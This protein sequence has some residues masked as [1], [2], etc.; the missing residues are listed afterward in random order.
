MTGD[1][2]SL[3][4]QERSSED[5]S[6]VSDEASGTPITQYQIPMVS[7]GSI[8]SIASTETIRPTNAAPGTSPSSHQ[9]RRKINTDCIVV[10]PSPAIVPRTPLL[11][12]QPSAPS[13]LQ[14]I[15]QQP[16]PASIS[17]PR[18]PP[19]SE[20]RHGGPPSI[21]SGTSSIHRSSTRRNPR[22]RAPLQRLSSY[23]QAEPAYSSDEDS[24]SAAE[25]DLE[26]VQAELERSWESQP[27]ISGQTG[28]VRQRHVRRHSVGT[29]RG[30]GSQRGGMRGGVVLDDDLYDPSATI[31]RQHIPSQQGFY[32]RD[33][34]DEGTARYTDI[35]RAPSRL[36]RHHHDEEDDTSSEGVPDSEAS[37]TLK[38]RQDAINITHPFGLK[39]WKPAL[40]KKSRSVQRTAEGEIH[41]QPGQWPDRK[42]R[43]G[44]VLWTLLFGW[45]MSII[46]TVLALLLLLSTW[47][48]GGAPY[49]FVLFGLARYL[50]YPFGRFVELQPDEAYAE[51]DEGEGRSISEYE[52][53]GAVDL[54]RGRQ[55]GIFS[56]SPVGEHRRGLV[57]R[58][59]GMSMGSWG[60]FSERDS[61]LGADREHAVNDGE[62]DSGPGRK[63]RF[64]GRGQW[65]L[66][67]IIFFITFYLIIGIVL[68]Y[69]T[70]SRTCIVF[71]LRDMLAD[72]VCPSDGKS[73]VHPC[74]PSPSASFINDIPFRSTN[75]RFSS[76]GNPIRSSFVMYLS[77]MGV[78]I[79]QIHR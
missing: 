15:P 40:Y 4:E 48:S 73:Y 2:T 46:V 11:R 51:E 52:R 58:R 8:D 62:E 42:I 3:N 22:L 44:N 5:G 16:L 27:A 36:S 26:T 21:T 19:V 7:P 18:L 64:F 6:S 31:R 29:S 68:V 67:R 69:V 61:L 33:G 72:S 49:A 39:I 38:D 14:H 55:L 1:M 12:R 77:S 63:R 71:S 76:S 41:S 47:W 56:H 45:W 23:S 75:C 59:R 9:P 28:T 37:F 35:D 30:K 57:G 43:L 10:P 20:G 54:E 25:A 17:S 32:Q 70:D 34:E 66:G 50:L 78:G 74:F 53:Y 79:L 24:E 13:T 60:E 65:S